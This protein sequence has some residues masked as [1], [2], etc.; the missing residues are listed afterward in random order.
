MRLTSKLVIY[1]PNDTE[2]PVALLAMW[3]GHESVT[4]PT[5]RT[6][7]CRNCRPTKVPLTMHSTSQ[8]QL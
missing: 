4:Q 2:G 5:E 3:S 8:A 7:S 6:M 1:S